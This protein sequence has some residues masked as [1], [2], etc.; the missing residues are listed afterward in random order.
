MAAEISRVPA[1]GADACGSAPTPG[2]LFPNPELVWRGNL[3]T[4]GHWDASQGWSSPCGF[5]SSGHHQ[6][7]LGG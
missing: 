7:L 1:W 2:L 3:A 6:A 5:G 4:S